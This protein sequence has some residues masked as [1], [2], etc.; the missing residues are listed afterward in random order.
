VARRISPGLLL[1]VNP[2]LIP[3]GRE[4]RLRG[5][6]IFLFLPLSSVSR[7]RLDFLLGI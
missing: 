5:Y 4:T 2:V 7:I 3:R 6:L 1:L